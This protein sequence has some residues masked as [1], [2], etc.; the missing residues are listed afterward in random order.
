[1]T[2]RIPA[3]R[4][5]ATLGAI[6]ALA[7]LCAGPF[8]PVAP[9]SAQAQVPDVA[10][11]VQGGIRPGWRSDS[12]THVAALHLTLA[13]NW[14]TYWRAPGE[15]GIPPVFDWAGSQNISGVTFHWP[16]PVVFEQS[17]MLSV[18]Y[19]RE[20]VLPMEFTLLDP[21]APARITARI[22]LGVC[23]TV[24]VPVA[25]RI[26][27]DLRPDGLDDRVIRAA[28]AD[29]P[30]PASAMGLTALSC[31]IQ[32]ID[33]GLRVTATLD[34]PDLG[35][36]EFMV[37]ELSDPAIW[38]SESRTARSGQRITA[39]S[40]MVPPSGAPFALDRSDLRITIL[41]GTQ[42]VE[43]RGCPGA[44]PAAAASAAAGTR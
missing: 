44:A 18:G 2:H 43:V 35:G 30:R 17:G 29:R 27:A 16:R 33:D 13:E 14:K 10:Q 11:I 37:F 32:P 12:G 42:A 1:M 3:P 31:D 28:L 4:S 5:L 21:A 8:G 34:I 22:D 15:A 23:E 40:D 41:R 39:T 26:E 7:A 25:L 24:C 9:R 36:R 20:L 19:A 6:A 38:I